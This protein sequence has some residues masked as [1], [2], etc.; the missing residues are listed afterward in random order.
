M[1]QVGG[2]AAQ[3]FLNSRTQSLVGQVRQGG[4]QIL[5]PSMK[6][7]SAFLLIAEPFLSLL[8]PVK[9]LPARSADDDRD[10]LLEKGPHAQFR[11]VDTAVVEQGSVCQR[12]LSNQDQGK[13]GKAD[14]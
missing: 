9:V 2:L 6:E 14:R 5:L 4:A 12:Q 7:Q 1:L 8:L 10:I 13:R 3:A 11:F